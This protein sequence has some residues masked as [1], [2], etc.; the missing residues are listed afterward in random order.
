MIAKIIRLYDMVMTRVRVLDF[1]APLALRIYLFPVFWMAGSRKLHAAESTIAWFDKGLGLP[2]PTLMYWL[3]TLTEL[4]GAV[5]L[6]FGLATPVVT[7]PL[8]V[9]MLVAIFAVHWGH[10]WL[11]IASSQPSVFTSPE[12][13][14]AVS[15][16]LDQ[17]KSILREHGNY[18]WLTEQGSFVV[19]NN[20]IEMAVTYFIMLL[21]LFYTGAGRYVS[22][23]YWLSC[24]LRKN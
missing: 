2:L 16:R 3:A 12:S 10:G 24:F 13:A 7:I 21:V 5:L 8:M 15:R 9:T 18:D 1:L 20:G 17:A 19:L 11:A 4:G 23:D 22:M 6:L 14:E